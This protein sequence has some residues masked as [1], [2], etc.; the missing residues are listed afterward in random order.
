MTPFIDHLRRQWYIA[1]DHKIASAKPF[2]YLI[3][4][5]IKTRRYLKQFNAARW[6]YAH[7]LISHKRHLHP[8]TFRRSEQNILDHH[9]VICVHPLSS[10]F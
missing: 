8:G 1:C 4:S 6:R 10:P 3:V 2:N 7:R 5:D 9:G